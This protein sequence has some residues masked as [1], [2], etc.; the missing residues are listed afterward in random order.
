MHFK[1]FFMHVHEPIT[2]TS[3]S[4]G[5]TGFLT[6]KSDFR[7]RGLEVVMKCEISNLCDSPFSPVWPIMLK[8][9]PKIVLF[10]PYK[11]DQTASQ[12][13]IIIPAYI[14]PPIILLLLLSITGKYNCIVY[15]YHILQWV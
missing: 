4:E 9:Y 12:D 5:V 8:L 7:L 2:I 15:N 3:A 10:S 1:Q 11:H 6:T 14:P 13:K